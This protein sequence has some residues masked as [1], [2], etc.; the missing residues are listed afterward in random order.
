MAPL[1]HVELTKRCGT[2]TPI[3]RQLTIH[4]TSKPGGV[5]KT[6][7]N[8]RKSKQNQKRKFILILIFVFVF[9]LLFI[10]VFVFHFGFRFCFRFCFHFVLH[11]RFDFRFCFCFC[12]HLHLCFCYS[13]AFGF[14]IDF[15]FLKFVSVNFSIV[16]LGHHAGVSI[17]D[18]KH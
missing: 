14:L 9:I 16:P 6:Q 18:F 2:S 10:W 4:G 3:K 5:K 1:G 15:V 17:V 7:K 12:F 13:Y 11:F 8:F